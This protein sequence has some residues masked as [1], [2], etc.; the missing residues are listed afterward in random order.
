V[1]VFETLGW[2]LAILLWF[3]ATFTGCS[4]N[5]RKARHLELADRY[6]RGGEYEK[7]K[8]EYLNVLREDFNNPAA[9]SRLGLIWFDE[10]A[11]L[12]AYAYL[13]KARDLNPDNVEVRTKLATVLSDLGENAA[14]REEAFAILQQSPGQEDALLVLTNTA[15]TEQEIEET[16]EQLRKIPEGN[17][18]GYHLAWASLA[19]R[20][21]DF[22]YAESELQEALKLA[23]RSS[24]VHLALANLFALR[25]KPD[26]A[27]KEFQT[28][29]E[30]SPPRSAARIKYAEYERE[31]G[32]TDKAI[33]ILK[34][35]TQQAPD[36]LPA[37]CLLAEWALVQQNYEEASS[38]VEDVLGRD[39]QNLHGLIVQA[40]AWLGKG[41]ANK[42]LEQL[43]HLAKAYPN[44]PLIDYHL[45]RA[46]LADGKLN[47][48]AAALNEAIAAK[49]D[50]TEAI[51]LLAQI[52]LRTSNAPLVV[53]AMSALLRQQPD[54]LSAQLLLTEAYCALERFDD[55]AAIAREQIRASPQSPDPYFRFGLILRQQHKIDQARIVFENASNLAPNSF[56]PVDQLVELDISQKS[57]DA[58]T[59]RVEKLEN[60]NPAAAHYLFGKIYAAEGQWDRA[61]A[62]FH[63]AL[64]LDPNFSKA[65]ELLISTYLLADRPGEAIDEL[66]SLL[67]K[68]PTDSRALADL[69]LIFDQIKDYPKAR[70][71]YEKLL[72][73]TPDD[74]IA[75]NNLAYLYAERLGQLDKAYELARKARALQPNN[76]LIADTLG[77]TLY[78][79]GDYQEALRLLRESAGKLAD[80]AAAQFHF[81]MAS[82]MMCETDAAEK[83][84]QK[85]VAADIETSSKTEAQRRLTFLQSA[86]DGR[87]SAAQLTAMIQ[88]Q[89]DD[90]VVWMR[91]GDSCEK[92][93]AFERA[94]RAY[95]EA[96]KVNPELVP[97]AVKLAQLNAGPLENTNIAFD[98]AKRA[99]DLAPNNPHI[100]GILGEIVY[101][102]G[103]FTWAYSLL[104]ESARQ[105][106][107]DPKIL[108]EYAWAAYSLGRVSES[109]S[110]MQRV[111]ETHPD[112]KQLND[113]KSFLAMTALDQNRDHLA[114]SEPEIQKILDLDPRYIPAL[115]ARADL[116]AQRGDA[117]SAS[118]IYADVL[119]RYRDFAPAQKRLAFLYMA[120][121]AHIDDA[122]DLAL[123]ARNA[124]PD[125]PELAKILGEISYKRKEFTYA[126]QLFQE[127]A[128]RKPLRGADLYY[129]GMS[130]FRASQDSESRKTLEQA[131]TTGLQEPLLGEAKATIT[132]L[133]RREGL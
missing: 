49:P 1:R 79:Q 92:E 97:A 33:R 51:L 127:S 26:E 47:E 129:L 62:S 44:V 21:R 10:G 67:A 5:S 128:R 91:L 83:A 109:R 55:A 120:D 59:H 29:A 43:D 90:V 68:T 30:L 3:A 23:P 16:E 56:D 57:F 34:E 98:F 130:Q 25:Q 111:L 15:W 87:V 131:L 69:A 126:I 12:R 99:R 13:S 45:A 42:A 63:Q 72:S 61:L 133:R 54:L 35:I 66:Q 110:I 89:P 60:A 75:I 125:D 17:D 124:F 82:Y 52:N 37:S 36:Y 70:D 73:V 7:A 8:I 84:L 6:F 31:I 58:A 123:K 114:S 65:F 118:S 101:Q 103:N 88:Q 48:A 94:G 85:A 106:T 108:Q 40:E 121:P 76:P 95:E 32:S 132:E 38:L 14:A 96:L 102:L 113:A 11:P 105:L 53:S 107:N 19:V 9:E 78:K 2:R 27:S 39:P 104:Q 93:G 81:G 46:C 119:R 28:A 77:W 74:P 4:G 117:K 20:K 116:Q 100:A 18:L 41:E 112:S 64:Q 22:A 86:A 71:A 115:M 80:K 24:R 50:Y 122:Y